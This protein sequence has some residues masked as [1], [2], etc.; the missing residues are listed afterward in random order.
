MAVAKSSKVS[1]LGYFYVTTPSR[2]YCTTVPIDSSLLRRLVSELRT[3]MNCNFD[4]NSCRVSGEEDAAIAIGVVAA[5][6]PCGKYIGDWPISREDD[7]RCV[8]PHGTDDVGMLPC[9]YCRRWAA[10]TRVVSLKLEE[11]E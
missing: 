5:L 6:C 9:E 1:S 3:R 11:F 8:P 4:G 7:A 2:V 10:R